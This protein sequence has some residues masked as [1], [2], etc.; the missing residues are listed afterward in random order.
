MGRRLGQRLQEVS[1]RSPTPSGSTSCRPC[2]ASWSRSTAEARRRRKAAAPRTHASRR[3]PPHAGYAGL[4]LEP[5]GGDLSYSL[6][7]PERRYMPPRLCWDRCWRAGPRPRGPA[8]QEKKEAA[9]A[10]AASVGKATES[11]SSEVQGLE[12]GEG[13]DHAR[14]VG[15]VM[16][17]PLALLGAPPPQR[18]APASNRRHV[19]SPRPLSALPRPRPPGVAAFRPGVGDSFLYRFN[20]SSRLPRPSSPTHLRQWQGNLSSLLM[21]STSLLPPNARRT[22]PGAPRSGTAPPATRAAAATFSS[23]ARGRGSSPK[24]KDGATK[25]GTQTSGRRQQ[26]QQQD[27][28]HS[29]GVPSYL[30]HVQSKIKPQLD[31]RRDFQRKVRVEPSPRNLGG[32]VGGWG[33]EVGGGFVPAQGA[34]WTQGIDLCLGGGNGCCARS[35]LPKTKRCWRRSPARASRSGTR[36]MTPIGTTCGRWRGRQ[37]AER[38][39]ASPGGCRAVW[40][41]ERRG[42]EPAGAEPVAEKLA[43]PPGSRVGLGKASRRGRLRRP[44]WRAL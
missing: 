43:S 41:V 42:E 29:Y 2:T 1:R 8:T 20:Q 16:L 33:S 18:P 30:K 5:V 34:S 12:G 9:V 19:R 36:S 3:A 21:Q 10:A 26:P 13:Q 4:F 6:P 31:A 35:G 7:Q 14:H 37:E 15:L 22:S 28:P 40:P 23:R 44:S 25:P 32:V 24:P 11:K 17:T 38:P 39:T 27:Q